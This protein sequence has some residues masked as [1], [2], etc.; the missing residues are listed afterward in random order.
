[1]RRGTAKRMLSVV[2]VVAVAGVMPLL[3]ATTASADQIACTEYVGSHGYTVGPKV[4]AACSHGVIFTG[5]GKTAN[6]KCLVGLANL[7]VASSVSGKACL[8]A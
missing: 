8:R 1:M 7:N 5:I 2:G 3:T 6:P 4:R